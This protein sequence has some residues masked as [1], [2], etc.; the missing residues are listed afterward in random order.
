MVCA[1]LYAVHGTAARCC[2]RYRDHAN[3]NGRVVCGRKRAVL[4]RLPN[5]T[6]LRVLF[7]ENSYLLIYEEPFA[8]SLSKG[9]WFDRLTTNGLV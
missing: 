4:G 3:E 5:G 9:V 1:V 2:G 6:T 7:N 8:L